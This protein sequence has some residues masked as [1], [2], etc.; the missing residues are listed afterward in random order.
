MILHRTIGPLVLD[1]SGSIYGGRKGQ[2]Q[3]AEVIFLGLTS[4]DSYFSIFVFFATIY[5]SS[6]MY[7]LIVDYRQISSTSRYTPM[8]LLV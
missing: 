6:T 4:V 7:E 3:C 2:G 8:L 5:L 1:F